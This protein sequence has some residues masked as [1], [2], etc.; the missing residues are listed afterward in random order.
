[1]K[2]NMRRMLPL[3]LLA[4]ALPAFADIVEASLTRPTAGPGLI[5]VQPSVVGLGPFA[6]SGYS[7][8]TIGLADNQGAVRGASGGNY[9]IP[10]AGRSG[11][12][13]EY[14]LGGFN[15]GLTT[16]AGDSGIYFSTGNTGTINIHF[17]A[18][19][20]SFALLWGSIDVPNSLSLSGDGS[21]T[22]TGAEVQAATAHFTTDGSQTYGGSAW[23]VITPGFAFDDVTVRSGVVSFEFAGAAG[24]TFHVP[25]PSAAL[26]LAVMG[27]VLL[28][29]MSVRKRLA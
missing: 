8:T 27:G 12:T 22:I 4:A 18:P 11:A 13:N 21:L 7:V 9:A 26:L 24:G 3:F 19:Q 16:V 20:R 15:S 6:G 10:V 5:E 28:A 2:T 23:V 25:E 1:V 14:L 29:L 17:V